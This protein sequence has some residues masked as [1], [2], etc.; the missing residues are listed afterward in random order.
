MGPIGRIAAV[1]GQV[2]AWDAELRAW[3]P[4]E[5]SRPL[6]AGDRVSTGPVGR[7]ELQVGSSTLRL[8]SR[9]ELDIAALDEQGLVL[10]LRR[11]SLALRLRS[12][13]PASQVEVVTPE[14]R[15]LPLE[16][17]HYRFDR[18][19]AASGEMNDRTQATVWQGRLQVEGEQGFQLKRGEQAEL[20]LEGATLRHSWGN[21]AEDVF[22]ERVLREDAQES[23]LYATAPPV[24]LNV[25]GA[26]DLARHGRWDRHPEFGWVWLP[27]QVHGGWA[28]YQQGR[29]AWVQPW[30]WTWV[31]HAPWSFATYHHGRWLQWGP[32]WAWA[33]LAP[34]ERYL[35]PG[36]HRPP[37]YKPPPVGYGPPHHRPPAGRGDGR[38]EPRP[39]RRFDERG[40]ARTDERKD[41]RMRMP[42]HRETALPPPALQPQRPETRPEMRPAVRPEA[43]PEGRSEVRPDAPRPERPA[44]PP[45][46]R[47]HPA[48]SPAVRDAQPARLPRPGAPEQ[49][50]EP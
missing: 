15:L 45:Q 12:E 23:R 1:Q 13:A 29:W 36:A 34:R 43:R 33:P 6:A 27:L 21:P 38:S 8:H 48:P 50:A 32:R 2:Y 11:G 30:G 42:A 3:A 18:G 26:A 5:P 47:P 35:P 41:W 22:A 24:P 46:A 14:A 4:A 39:D 25:T 9:T 28:P 7:A 20:W 16:P 31:D 17:G 44:A 19:D 10:A 49:H 40:E 37:A